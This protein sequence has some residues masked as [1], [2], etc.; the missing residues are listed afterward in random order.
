VEAVEGA[1]ARISPEE[2]LER[3]RAAAARWRRSGGSDP[4]ALAR[5][6]DRKGFARHAI[7]RVLRE[8]APDAPTPDDTD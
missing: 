3:A 5:H 4:D 1:V 8:F 2:D 6:L 7:F